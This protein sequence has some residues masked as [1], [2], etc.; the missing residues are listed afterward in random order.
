M[1]SPILRV[2]LALALVYLSPTAVFAFQPGADYG[3]YKTP[4][5]Y[6]C[7]GTSLTSNV[8]V[9][10][11]VD[12][13]PQIEPLSDA[14]WEQWD[15]FMH[16]TFP[17]IMRWYQGDQSDCSSSPTV[18]KIDVAILNVNGTNVRTTLVGPLTYKND[19]GVKAISIGDNTFHW[20]DSTHW[21]NLT[22]NVEGYSLVLNTY[23][24]MLDTF[25]PNVGYYNGRLSSVGDPAFFGSVPITRGQ[26]AGYLLTPD[27]Q[28]ITVDG[29]TT[30][31]HM[32]SK[33]ALPEYISGYSSAVV[34]G[35]S[36][37]FYDTHVFFKI[38]ETNGTVHEAAYI[39]RAIQSPQDK[40]TFQATYAIYAVTDDIALY[41]LTI[42]QGLQTINST[43]PGCSAVNNISYAFNLTLA[44]VLG[45][46]TDLGGGK[47]T[48]YTLNGTT[49]APSGGKIVSAPIAGAF[50]VYQA[51]TSK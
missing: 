22:L 2:F 48:Y 46:F 35:Y 36:T 41:H 15:F 39:G 42:N 3:L 17:I 47:T 12:T 49:T 23:S 11:S 18:G 44:G 43:F 31:K 20:D 19:A 4:N 5:L 24:A 50:E 16:G 8:T 40:T 34:W 51:P 27:K 9:H 6:N 14:G 37:G 10:N 26:S 29:L 30:M 28:N 33:K 45:E 21:Y 7:S 1:L 13:L 38:D 25:H 32:F